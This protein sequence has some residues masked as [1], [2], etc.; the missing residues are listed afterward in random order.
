MVQRCPAVDEMLEPGNGSAALV[1]LRQGDRGKLFDDVH[2]TARIAGRDCPV[3]RAHSALGQRVLDQVLSPHLTIWRV[4]EQ[5]SEQRAVSR[6]LPRASGAPRLVP[7]P[8]AT[9]L[10]THDLQRCIAPSTTQDGGIVPMIAFGTTLF[11]WHKLASN[12][13]ESNIHDKEAYSTKASKN[14]RPR[15]AIGQTFH[16]AIILPCTFTCQSWRVSGQSHLS[17]PPASHAVTISPR[18]APCQG[19][20]VQDKCFSARPCCGAW[21]RALA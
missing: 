10:G 13:I 18:S 3:Y 21:T 14:M 11:C 15:G 9:A 12:L 7:G 4:A 16:G 1:D 20:C 17:R 2:L 8:E 5:L 6:G 19:D